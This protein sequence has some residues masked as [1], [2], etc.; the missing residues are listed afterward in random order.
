MGIF[1]G[2]LVEIAVAAG[3]GL[4]F[5]ECPPPFPRPPTPSTTA[6]MVEQ[7][8]TTALWDVSERSPKSKNG[9]TGQLMPEKKPVSVII[10]VNIV[11]IVNLAGSIHRFH[12]AE[13]TDSKKEEGEKETERKRRRGQPVGFDRYYHHRIGEG[14][15][16]PVATGMPPFD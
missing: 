16:M 1:C 4:K 8:P 7:Q 5:L 13:E 15:S 12:G 10:I 2:W 14:D 6:M 11:N 3:R 9:E